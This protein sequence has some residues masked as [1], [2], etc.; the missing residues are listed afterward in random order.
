[1][2]TKTITLLDY[3]NGGHDDE[4]TVGFYTS[5]GIPAGQEILL[6]HPDWTTPFD[7]ALE[8][9]EG[10]VGADGIWRWNGEGEPVDLKH[11]TIT[12]VDAWHDDIDR[13]AEFL[14]EN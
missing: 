1:M 9:L 11:N 10:T 4:C 13:M 14:A 5:V 8:A 2:D 7:E 12:R 3:I 6:G